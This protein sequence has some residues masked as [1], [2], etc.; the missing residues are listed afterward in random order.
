MEIFRRTIEEMIAVI[1][2]GHF[3]EYETVLALLAIK[4]L[5]VVDREFPPPTRIFHPDDKPNVAYRKCREDMLKVS[6][7]KEVKYGN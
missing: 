7:I 1:S 6:Y 3:D 4:S 2:S 5:A